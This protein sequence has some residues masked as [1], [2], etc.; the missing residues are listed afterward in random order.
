MTRKIFSVFFQNKSLYILIVL[1]SQNLI[2]NA[3]NHDSLQI[4]KNYLISGFVQYGKILATNAFLRKTFLNENAVEEFAAFSLQFMKQTT[5]KKKWEQ[6][7]GFPR[8]GLGVYS[9][10]FFNKNGLGNPIAVYGIF[11]APF[12]R[13]NKLSLNYEAGFGYTFNWESF[14][15]IENNYNPSFG[16]EQSFFIDLGVSLEYQISRHYDLS[17]GYDFTHFSNGALKSPNSGLNIYS[18]KLS[19]NYRLNPFNPEQLKK[20]IF[21]YIKNT[22]IDFLV[23]GG[24]KNVIY[25]NSNAVDT[26]TKYLGVYYPVYGL[27]AVINRQLDYKSKVGIGIG[28]SYDGSNN[29]TVIVNNGKLEPQVG[30]QANRLALS[31]FAS[32]E[33]VIDQLSL[34]VQPGFYILRYQTTNLKPIAYQRLG[35]QYQFRKCLFAGLFLHAYNYHISDYLEWTLGYRISI[36]KKKCN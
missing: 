33:L 19:L 2:A 13:W 3:Q 10:S 25:L 31:I 7:Y 34:V 5:G 24:T 21:P 30:F 20:P 23:F 28:L 18:P 36:P 17:L 29:S 27:S 26:T 12:Y 15:L 11:K 6:A 8:Y 4:K 32:Y 14:S 35:L 22:T 1:M 9:A 16:A